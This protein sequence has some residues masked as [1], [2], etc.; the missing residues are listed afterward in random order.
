MSLKVKDLFDIEIFKNFRLVAGEGGLNRPIKTTEI[1]DFEFIQGADMDRKNVFEGESITL[2]SLLYAIENPD[3]I[4]EAVRRLNE[5][6]VSCMAYKTAVVSQLPQEA[7][8]YANSHNFPIL[9]FGGDEFFEDIIFAVRSEIG[10]GQDI[11]EIEMSLEDML[12]KS[13][14]AREV[15][16]FVKRL[17][18]EFKRYVRGVGIMGEDL[19]HESVRSLLKTFSRHEK[20]GR[21]AALCKF[22][23]GYFIF[24]TQDTDESSR[25]DALLSDVLAVLEA[26]PSDLH[27]GFS[28]IKRLDGQFDKVVREAFWSCIVASL[29]ER[30]RKHYEEL[31][32]YRFITSEIN[33]E[34][35]KEYAE[36]FLQPLMDGDGELLRTA[37]TYV[38]C[39]GD[40]EAAAERL[41]C[42]KN[43]VRYRLAKIQELAAPSTNEKEFF[44]NLA[45]AIRIYMLLQYKER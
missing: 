23:E 22:R 28:T 37:K 1:L 42:H 14:S 45:L 12:D 19:T 17:N 13:L 9:E 33:S 26:D 2:T 35:L 29:E 44:E 4:T 11:V 31:G 39:R 30:P 18:P 16:R 43:T 21:K 32:I 38:M 5:L 7:I 6:N 25:F 15:R 8:D 10:A 34:S 24:L 27:M 41:F 40:M 36:E 3:L 20:I